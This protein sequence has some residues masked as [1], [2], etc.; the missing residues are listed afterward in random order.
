MAGEEL[1]REGDREES[2]IIL[3][4]AFIVYSQD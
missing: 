4:C 1:D 3:M 2:T